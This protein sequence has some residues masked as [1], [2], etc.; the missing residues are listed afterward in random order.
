MER[1]SYFNGIGASNPRLQIDMGKYW[2][3][4]SKTMEYDP[5]LQDTAWVKACWHFKKA[6]ELN[7][8]KKVKNEIAGYV[9]DIY[10]DQKRVREAVE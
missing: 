6:L 3:M 4:R 5:V 2:T 10:T 8:S 1:A 9:K 7:S